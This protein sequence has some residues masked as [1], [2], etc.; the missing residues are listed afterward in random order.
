L[1][2]TKVEYVEEPV[3]TQIQVAPKAQKTGFGKRARRSLSVTT[4]VPEAEV[5][6]DML[7]Q[8]SK[9]FDLLSRIAAGL[10]SE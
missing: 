6:S 1:N 7:I 4:E 8:D 9:A 10:E 2:S 5:W 3:E